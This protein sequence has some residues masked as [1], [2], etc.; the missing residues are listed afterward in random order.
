MPAWG[1]FPALL[2]EHP[3][4][5]PVID[6]LVR[7]HE[8]VAS[9]LVELKAIA[10]RW[11]ADDDVGAARRELDGLAAVLENHFRYEERKLV[12]MLDALDVPTASDEFDGV[13]RALAL[14]REG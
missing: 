11:T 12:S 4:L 9:I 14:A 1:V 6:D 3:D 13:T 10:E 5:R 7:D 2:K 8:F